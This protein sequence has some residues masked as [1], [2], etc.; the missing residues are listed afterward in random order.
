MRHHPKKE[1]ERGRTL[2]SFKKKGS[3]AVSYIYFFHEEGKEEEKGE[4][5]LIPSHLHFT[6]GGKEKGPYKSNFLLEGWK[7]RKKMT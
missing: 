1:R 2:H 4:E 3:A 7:G 6:N 5:V